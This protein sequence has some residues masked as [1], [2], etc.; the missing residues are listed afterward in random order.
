MKHSI[1]LLTLGVFLLL[2]SLF[3]S[4]IHAGHVPN[5]QPSEQKTTKKASKKQRKSHFNKAHH[6]RWEK[7]KED[8]PKVLKSNNKKVS[9]VIKDKNPRTK[10][11]SILF[12]FGIALTLFFG[13]VFLMFAL[14]SGLNGVS[15]LS[16]LLPLMII[17]LITYLVI[18]MF[19]RL[20]KPKSPSDVA[21]E[22]QRA[23]TP[24]ELDVAQR[25]STASRFLGIVILAAIAGLI[26]F[27]IK[28]TDYWW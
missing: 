8:S 27:G 12:G 23:L 10:N 3:Y 21:E 9:K 26:T 5:N 2:F 22:K 11:V 13:I 4:P 24:E 20:L 25:R 6:K 19:K 15:F 18:R 16:P 17:F 7:I 1:Y 14:G 28:D